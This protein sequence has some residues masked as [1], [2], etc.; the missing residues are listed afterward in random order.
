MENMLKRSGFTSSTAYTAAGGSIILS[1]L[2]WVS[3][4]GSDNA[5]AE[6]FG[7]FVGLW[8]P[9][10]MTLGKILEDREKAG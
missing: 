2:I 6:R 4:R 1:I 3:R 5:N 10:F 7:I 9:T 8:A